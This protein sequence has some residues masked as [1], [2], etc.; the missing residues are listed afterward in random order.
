MAKLKALVM[1]NS[2]LPG[3][4]RPVKRKSLEVT[5]ALGL[6]GKPLTITGL[7]GDRSATQKSCN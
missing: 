3:V 7:V 6:Q 5:F 2:E 4:L 1:S